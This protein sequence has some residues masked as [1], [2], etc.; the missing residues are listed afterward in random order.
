[1]RGRVSAV[2]MA[3]INASNELG[4]FE[5]GITAALWGTV[6]AVIFGGAGTCLVV[7]LWAYLFP[8]LRALE[9]LTDARTAKDPGRA[10]PMANSPDIGGGS[11]A[12]VSPASGRKL[13]D[14]LQ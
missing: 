12:A 5:S 14:H 6:P 10:S 2:N 1:M 3:F 9:R 4:E 8:E 11:P 7:L 13:P